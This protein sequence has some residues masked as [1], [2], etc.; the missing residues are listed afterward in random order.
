[1][2]A[3]MMKDNYIDTA[4]SKVIVEIR[5]LVKQLGKTLLAAAQ[6]EPKINRAL[7]KLVQCATF[8]RG[9]PSSSVLNELGRRF[10]LPLIDAFGFRFAY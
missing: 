9:T 2:S 5:Q 8:E 3:A 10:K 4:V 7:A 6:R 1:M